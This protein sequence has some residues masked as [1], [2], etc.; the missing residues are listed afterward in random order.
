MIRLFEDI[1]VEL[2][3]EQPVVELPPKPLKNVAK[4]D[5]IVT[6]PSPTSVRRLSL[7]RQEAEAIADVHWHGDI[8]NSDC[9]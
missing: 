3:T 9:S 8:T 4:V 1:L 5:I 2:S 6:A 7:R